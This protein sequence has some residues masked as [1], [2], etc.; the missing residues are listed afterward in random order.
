[1]D[2]LVSAIIPTHHR[3]EL[4]QRA[5]RSALNQTYPN[6]EVVVVID[7]P[8]PNTAEI[9]EAFQEPRLR[10]I[11]LEKN[12]G[13]SAARNAGIRAAS[14]EWIGL[15][16]DDDEWLPEKIEK[17]LALTHGDSAVNFLGCRLHYVEIFINQAIPRKFPQPGEDLGEYLYCNRNG[18]YPSTFVIKRQLMLATPFNDTLCVT[19]D[20]DWLLR[21]TAAGVLVPRWCDEALVIIHD[22]I[23]RPHHVLKSNWRVGFQW[24]I[25]NRDRLLTRKAFTY[26]I[27]KLCVLTVRR[28]DH[29]IRDSLYLLYV[30]TFKGRIDLRFLAYYAMYVLFS[31]Y[32]RRK[33]RLFNERVKRNIAQIL[34]QAEGDVVG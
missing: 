2:P 30:A 15:L 33:M 20:C 11:A 18:L 13:L 14:G 22:D 25:S 10:V 12:G 27:L 26:S 7:G 17:Q 31:D 3:T 23:F 9:L 24:A 29:P 28:S 32:S 21:T 5:V 4:V 8:E 19:E 34:G 16:D 6:M 1:M